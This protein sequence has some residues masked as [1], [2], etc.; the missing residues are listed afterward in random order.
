MDEISGLQFSDNEKVVG[1]QTQAQFC[2]AWEAPTGRLLSPLSE[3]IAALKSTSAPIDVKDLFTSGDDGRV[4]RWDY[5]T[6]AP[7][8]QIMLHPARL[9]GQPLLRPIVV[10]TA[11]ATRASGTRGPLEVFDVA[12]GTDLFVAPPPSAACDPHPPPWTSARCCGSVT[13][14]AP[15]TTK[16]ASA[17]ISRS[18]WPAWPSVVR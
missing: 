3:H 16:P 18:A 5:V 4:F 1:W 17:I 15:S 14:S 7:N 9:P 2:M 6:G 12:N 13:S 8:E 10:L 11:D